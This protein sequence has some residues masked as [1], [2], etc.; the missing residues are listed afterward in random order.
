[1]PTFHVHDT[2]VKLC[3][4]DPHHPPT[5]VM[6]HQGQTPLIPIDPAF[7]RAVEPLEEEYFDG[8]SGVDFLGSD[9]PFFLV[10]AGKGLLSRTEEVSKPI[11]ETVLDQGQVQSTAEEVY[12]DCDSPLSTV[13]SSRFAN[14]SPVDNRKSAT[15]INASGESVLISICCHFGIDSAEKQRAWGWLKPMCKGEE[16][17]PKPI[18]SAT[19]L[20]IQVELSRKSHLKSLCTNQRLDLCVSVFINGD[21]QNSRVLR[22]GTRAEEKHQTFGGRRIDTYLEAPWV[23]LPMSQID[24]PFPDKPNYT[25]SSFEDRWGEVNLLLLKEADQWGRTG[26]YDMFR[27]PVGEY[28]AELSKKPVPESMKNK[29]RTTCKA[30]I[31]DVSNRG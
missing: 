17:V 15:P 30:G 10:N 13:S 16:I 29:D 28:L 14:L 23:V 24:A 7:G 19:P 5:V 2:A 3:V 6:E 18:T 22:L 20:K 31:I 25:R 4:W 9:M 26:K 11:I 1:M 21:F 8:Q 27:N 12:D